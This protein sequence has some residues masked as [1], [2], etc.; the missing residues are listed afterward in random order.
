METYFYII[1]VWIINIACICFVAQKS[2]ECFI[3]FIEKPQG[4]KLI[5]QKISN[6]DHFPAITICANEDKLRWNTTHL[7]HCGIKG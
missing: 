6:I 2:T 3:K 1:T 7:N 4:T 5:I